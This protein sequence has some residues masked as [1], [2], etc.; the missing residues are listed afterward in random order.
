MYVIP[1]P[2]CNDHWEED[3]IGNCSPDGFCVLSHDGKAGFDLIESGRGD[4]V[5]T[6]YIGRDVV[7]WSLSQGEDGLDEGVRGTVGKRDGLGSN[8]IRLECLDAV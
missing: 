6:C 4:L 3:I 1:L 5:G 8:G 7:V 2:C